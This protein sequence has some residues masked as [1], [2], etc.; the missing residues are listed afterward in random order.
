MDLTRKAL[1]K[2]RRG[3]RSTRPVFS[4][5]TLPALDNG[6]GD[7]E[8]QDTTVVE[9]DEDVLRA[10]RIVAALE[11]EPL[12]DVYRILRTQVLRRLSAE[13]L[14]TLA[15]CSPG[16]G[17]GKT[18]TAVNL[19]ICLAMDVN[20]TVLLVDLDLRQPCVARILG[21]EPRAGIDDYIKGNAELAECLVNPGTERLVILPARAPMEKSSEMLASPRMVRLAHELKNRYPDRIVIYDMPPLLATD[22]CLAFMPHVDATMLVVSEGKTTKA[23]IERSLGMLRGSHMIG[24]ILND[25]MQQDYRVGYEARGL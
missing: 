3:K 9:L 4:L 1:E 21:M 23:E 2:A 8:Y 25:S 10:N 11:D 13:R 16:P 17:E 24:A 22:D 6:P 19:A 14:T 15:I 18:L 12:A 7:I 5:T 20:Q